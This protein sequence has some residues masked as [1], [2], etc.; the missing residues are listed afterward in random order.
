VREKAPR[1]TL[2]ERIELGRDDGEGGRENGL[3]EGGRNKES[4][5]REREGTGERVSSRHGRK[6]ERSKRK[7]T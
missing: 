5:K 4:R 7:L 2:I 3:R 1:L 6:R